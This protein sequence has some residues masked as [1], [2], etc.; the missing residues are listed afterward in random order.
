[1]FDLKRYAGN[2]ALV[3]GE[4]RYTYAQLDELSQSVADAAEKDTLAFIICS[5][6]VGSIAG[7]VGF[8]NNHI[9][10]VMVDAKIDPG[11]LDALLAGYHPAYIW[12][13]DSWADR[14]GGSEVALSAMDY[15]LFKTNDPVRY[16]LY[17]ELALL[18]T[19]SGSTGS[20]KLVRQ[21]YANLRANTRA[22]VEYL[23]ID[24]NERAITSLPMHYVYGLSVI[25]THLWAGATLLLTEQN[26]YAKQFWALFDG[27]GATSFAGVPF[28][29][30]MLDKL[31]ITAK[32]P[33]PTL[34]TMTQAGGKLLPSLQ[35]KFS[36]YAHET[37][38]KFVV[39]YGASEATARMGYLP[40]DMAVK[41]EGS[42]GIAIPGGSFELI[43]EN[44]AVIETPDT[45]GE[46]VYYGENVTLGYS[47]KGEDL[48]KGDENHGRLSTGDMARRDADGYYYITGRKKRFVKI[49]GKRLNLD[50]LERML[51][52]DCDSV[53]I[54]CAG[55]DDSLRIFLVDD[56]LREA[57]ERF[58]FEKTNVNRALFHIIHIDEIPKNAAGK[59]LY[60]ALNNLE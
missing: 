52:K 38:R 33:L 40:S 17:P 10:P 7:Y 15:T 39:M 41:K 16:P 31:K 4:A 49:L 51:K 45:E 36:Q 14:F 30:E 21:S 28:M 44:G 12:A 55:K 23:E 9:V 24:E 37:G 8:L 19:T 2:T 34:R 1:M 26:C 58:V 59:I 48:A 13:P 29:Y 32:R 47:E 54:A 43:D 46:L 35:S 22:I 57:V 60:S 18:I 50:E 25:N 3:Q 5:N 53:D 20:P 56:S 27:E 42:M 11:F 6:T